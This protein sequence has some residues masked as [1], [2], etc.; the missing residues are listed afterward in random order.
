MPINGSIEG[1]V[2]RT[3][4][5]L[6][7]KSFAQARE[8]QEIFA[9]SAGQQLFDDLVT[10][11]LRSVVPSAGAP[12]RIL[13]VLTAGYR[14]ENVYTDEDVAFFEQVAAQVAIAVDN[15]LHYERPEKTGINRPSKSFTYKRRFAP[16]ATSVK[17]SAIVAL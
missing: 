16:I 4:R 6:W 17:S 1:K 13:G 10:T 2:F 14:S 8:D 15:A 9:G 11:G 12:D 3:A 5:S 7:L